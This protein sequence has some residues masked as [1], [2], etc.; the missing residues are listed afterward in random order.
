MR[1]GD[2]VGLGKGKC[3]MAL[4][5]AVGLAVGLGATACNL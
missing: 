2:R 1:G 4:E 5:S 3:G